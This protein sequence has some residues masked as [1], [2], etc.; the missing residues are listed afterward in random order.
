MSLISKNE[1]KTIKSLS[2]KK[3]RDSCGLFAVEG[4]KMVD[5]A[6]HSGFKVERIFRK[7]EIGEQAMSRISSFSTPSPVLAVIRKP[8]HIA[9]SSYGMLDSILSGGGLFMALDKIRDPGNLGTIIRICDWF[10]VKALFASDDT[11][12]VFNPKVVQATM[13]AIFRLRFHYTDIGELC[14]RVVSGNGRVY[15][16]FL[17]GENIYSAGLDNGLESPSLVVIGNESEGISREIKGLV[18]DKINI[19]PYPD[20]ESGSESLNAAVA[21]AV[22]IAEFRRRLCT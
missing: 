13:G 7:E 16:T 4:E 22:T 8:D 3:Y 17:E 10:G 11:V 12:D 21:S 1:I 5:E 18:T 9:I 2:D 15:G 19:P 14:K 6:L 20:G